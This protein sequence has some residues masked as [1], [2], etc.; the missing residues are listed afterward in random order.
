M[1]TGAEIK[2]ALAA[3]VKRWSG[4]GG[5]ERAE[6]QTFL[7]DLFACYGSDRKDVGAR[8]EEFRTSSGFMDLYWPEVLIVEMKHPKQPLTRAAEQRERYWAESANREAGVRAAQDG[9]ELVR[10]LTERNREIT[11]GVRPYA[12]FGH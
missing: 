10:L 6:A 7:N 3:F 9:P 1:R 4:Y 2:L 8:F 5:T 12:P 11:E